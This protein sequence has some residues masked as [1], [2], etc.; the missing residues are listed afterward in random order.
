MMAQR[1]RQQKQNRRLGWFL[2]GAFAAMLTGSVLYIILYQR[3][4]GS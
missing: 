1:V 3:A 4:F 2:I